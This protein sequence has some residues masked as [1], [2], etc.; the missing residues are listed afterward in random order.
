MAIQGDGFFMVNSGGQQFYTRAGDFTFDQTGSLVTPDGAIVQGWVANNAGVVSNNST[1]TNLTLPLSITMAAT[2][3]SAATIAGNLP[4]GSAAGVVASP[5][6]VTMFDPQGTQVPITFTYTSLGGNQWTM[7]A[8]SGATTLA[9]TTLSFNGSGQL[10]SATPVTMDLSG[11]GLSATT[12]VDVSGMTEYAGQ[13]TAQ[14]LN[15]N[16][17]GPGSLASFSIGQDGVVTGIFTNGLK[18]SLG[19]VA[20]ATFTNP[21]G[22][23]KVGDTMFQATVNSGQAQI[24]TPTT[25]SH[26]AIASGAV[27]M[28][29]VDLGQEFT[30]LIVAQRGFE[31]NSKVIKASDEILQD[32][33]NMK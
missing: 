33:V 16:G 22:L 31:A 30:Q 3:T 26:G 2:Q 11:A 12:A 19:Q 8:M 15:Q 25:G 9:T 10:T 6:S 18:Q 29:N 1:P 27:E 20:L 7:N 17:S 24:G 32:L 4:A 21:G 28:S 14:V 23:Q 13:A 5:S